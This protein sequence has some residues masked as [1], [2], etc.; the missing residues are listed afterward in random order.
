M[1]RYGEDSAYFGRTQRDIYKE[2]LGGEALIVS[3]QGVIVR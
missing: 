2:A 3:P 1:A